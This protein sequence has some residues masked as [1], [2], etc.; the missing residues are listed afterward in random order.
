[1]LDVVASGIPVAAFG[2][3]TS[4]MGG[5]WIPNSVMA[6]G[7]LGTAG[8]P[9][10]AGV[11]GPL[12]RDPLIAAVTGISLIALVLAGKTGR[13]GACPPPVRASRCCSMTSP[14]SL[15]TTATRP[16]WPRSAST[17]RLGILEDLLPRLAPGG[18]RAPLVAR[19]LVR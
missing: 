6:K 8:K 5:G 9:L 14:A 17:R 18:A 3:F 15:G 2:L 1:V 19:A 10:P 12:R 16:T 4:I 13:R 7:G 11:A